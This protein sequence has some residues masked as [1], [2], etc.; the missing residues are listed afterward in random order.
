M[1]AMIPPLQTKDG[2]KSLA[3]GQWLESANQMMSEAQATDRQ[4]VLVVL[5]KLPPSDQEAFHTHCRERNLDGY[6]WAVAVSV[7]TRHYS[8]AISKLDAEAQRRFLPLPTDSDSFEEFLTKFTTLSF[9]CGDKLED[10]HVVRQLAVSLP[11]AVQQQLI[12]NA[13]GDE[14]LKWGDVV[15]LGRSQFRAANAMNIDTLSAGREAADTLDGEEEINNIASF[16]AGKRSGL[17]KMPLYQKVAKHCGSWEE[18]CRR[19]GK[20]L[21]L[22]C[23]SA[24]HVWGKCSLNRPKGRGD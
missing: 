16:S 10:Q 8:G 13:R 11:T 20:N 6:S 19:A 9:Q 15:A 23:G 14:N 18:Y 3:V 22:G 24:D 1:A 7:L 2:K 21:C 4:K 5:S 12:L 17:P